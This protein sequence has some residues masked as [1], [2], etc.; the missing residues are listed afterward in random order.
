MV[1]PWSSFNWRKASQDIFSSLWVELRKWAN[2]HQNFG[3]RHLGLRRSPRAAFLPDSVLIR[4]VSSSRAHLIQYFLDALAH[5]GEQQA[6]STHGKGG[7]ILDR[8]DDELG[9]RI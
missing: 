1:N 7:L 4:S 9:F 6:S 2:R 8:V 3:H 5:G